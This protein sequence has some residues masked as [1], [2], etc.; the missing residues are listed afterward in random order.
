MRAFAGWLRGLPGR[1]WRWM[2]TVPGRLARWY[3][4]YP[5]ERW[6]YIWWG[7][8]G[9]VV[10]VPELSATFIKKAPYPTISGFIGHFEQTQE[11]IAIIVIGVLVW[12]GFRAIRLTQTE[13][14]HTKTGS[15]EARKLRRVRGDWLTKAPRWKTVE[16][17]M[18]LLVVA[19][20]V[21]LGP[22]LLVVFV[23]G[24]HKYLLGGVMYGLIGL[25]FIGIP[26]WVAY[27]FGQ[28][29][30]YPTLF[31]TFKSLEQRWR[32]GAVIIGSGITVLMI[33]LVFYPWPA[34]IPDMN[35]LHNH[36]KCNPIPP[37][38]PPPDCPKPVTPSPEAP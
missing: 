11:W 27:K 10:A 1:S 35:R 31:A 29:L 32:P 13:M 30:P 15:N 5:E 34:V 17:P 38:H 21:V 24:S 36:Y 19:A 3:W 7:L 14:H 18:I 2:E 26:A 25:F 4:W 20:L 22:C 12:A 33:H 28:L 6:G 16:H 9:A 23:W 8:V 37:E